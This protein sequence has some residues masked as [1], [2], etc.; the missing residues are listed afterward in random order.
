MS[1][2]SGSIQV[3]G[4]FFDNPEMTQDIVWSTPVETDLSSNETTENKNYEY[5]RVIIL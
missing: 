1:L 3:T 2:P 5:R 4:V